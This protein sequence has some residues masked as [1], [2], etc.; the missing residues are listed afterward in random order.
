MNIWKITGF[1]GGYEQFLQTYYISGAY[2]P[3]S[4]CSPL[5]DGFYLFQ[6]SSGKLPKRYDSTPLPFVQIRMLSR[7]GI[8]DLQKFDARLPYFVCHLFFYHSG[9]YL[10]TQLMHMY[11]LRLT[12]KSLVEKGRCHTVFRVLRTKMVRFFHLVLRTFDAPC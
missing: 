6:I 8:N 4:C 2:I 11:R 1:I 10:R 7:L 9:G 5:T 12:F 3:Q